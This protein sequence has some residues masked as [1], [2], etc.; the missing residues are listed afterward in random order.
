MIDRLSNRVGKELT[1]Y[2]VL[3][4]GRSN[5]GK[6]T[7]FNR[8]LNGTK[9]ITNNTP[10]T[11]RDY[12]SYDFNLNDLSVRLY[13]TAGCDLNSPNNFLQKEIMIFNEKLIID[14]DLIL[15][16]VD[17]K[18]GLTKNDFEFA[19]YLRKF[20]SKTFLISNKHDSKKSL[21]SFWE[22][23][24]LGIEY[25]FPISAFH[26]LGIENLKK[27]ISVFLKSKNF[28]LK[29]NEKNVFF[30][31]YQRKRNVSDPYLSEINVNEL[32]SD[33]E[34]VK[35]AIVGRPNVG[36]STLL[37]TITKENRVLTSAK[38]G[39]TTDPILVKLNWLGE[40]FKIIDTA[41]MRRPSKI[42][43]GIEELSVDKSIEVIKFSEVVIMLLDTENALDAQDLKIINLI[44]KEG[45]CLILVIN[46]WDLEKNK[47]EK[48]NILKDK[49]KLSLPQ[50][51]DISL[52][53]IS[54]LKNKGLDKLK[55]AVVSA[56]ENWNK[57]L[58]TAK[59]NNWLSIKTA[60][61]P[62][63][64]F[65]GKRLKLRYITQIKSRPPNFLIF[66]SSLDIPKNY[67]KF[68]TNG[69]RDQFDLKNVPIRLGFR[70]GVNP[71]VKN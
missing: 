54:A 53:T 29:D 31:N 44:E 56:K 66:S 57:R 18:I 24:S 39:T 51:G 47:K 14:S 70:V 69:L 50:F 35:L 33:N 67:R 1:Q 49:I 16:V 19:S 42:T 15:F 59:L 10:G 25:S 2:N 4:T 63:P 38:S 30:K 43:K 28:N 46:K 45:R 13:D 8:L 62:P 26:G 23:L 36:K 34:L 11:T 22:P 71:Y 68:L 64:M 3:I 60:Q 40:N 48:I 37:N 61:H 27:E 7:L 5:V 9:S 52:V 12:K 32:S 17:S 55:K 41:G 65:K 58:N 6:S 21:Q 20:H